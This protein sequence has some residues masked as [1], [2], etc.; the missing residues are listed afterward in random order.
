MF[1]LAIH[2]WHSES[3]LMH[4]EQQ[5]SFSCAYDAMANLHFDGL[6]NEPLGVP[7]I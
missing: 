7:L 6:F 2:M 3:S 4:F 5:A 1:A